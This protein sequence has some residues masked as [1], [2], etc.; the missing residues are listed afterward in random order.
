MAQ[1]CRLAKIDLVISEKKEENENQ[2]I[3]NVKTQKKM[4]DVCSRFIHR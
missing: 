3:I 1:H 2:E 4:P